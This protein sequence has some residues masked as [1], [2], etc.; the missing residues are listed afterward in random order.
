MRSKFSLSGS[1]AGKEFKREAIKI[2]Q[3]SIVSN[4]R[5]IVKIFLPFLFFFSAL[6]FI[7]FFVITWDKSV[8]NLVL[9]L[10]E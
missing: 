6:L 10:P 4:D 8:V 5:E 3:R 2:K 1:S 9:N 7:F